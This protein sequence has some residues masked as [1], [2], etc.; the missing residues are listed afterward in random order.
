MSTGLAAMLLGTFAVPAVLLWGGH[1]MRRRSGRW[2]QAFWGG[3]IGHIIAIVVGTTAGMIPPEEWAAT[4][5]MRGFFAFWS[6]LVFPLLG[7]LAGWLR[8]R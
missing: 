5:V 3:V 6:F 4:D 2:R 1:R 7:G 8:G